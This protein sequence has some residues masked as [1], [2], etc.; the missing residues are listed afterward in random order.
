MDKCEARAR[1]IALAENT[2]NGVQRDALVMG[3]N[4]LIDD[5][6]NLW[7]DEHDKQIIDYIVDRIIFPLLDECDIG[8]WKHIDYIELAEKWVDA[9]NKN[10]YPIVKNCDKARK[11]Y[12]KKWITEQLKGQKK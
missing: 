7:I 6:V 9:I 2:P 1:L 10:Q 4:A 12:L 11:E 5:V 3:A 8:L